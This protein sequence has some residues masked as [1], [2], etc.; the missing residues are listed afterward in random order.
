MGRCGGIKATPDQAGGGLD[1]D[2]PM[3]IYGNYH[4]HDGYLI[5]WPGPVG[6]LPYGPWDDGVILLNSGLRSFVYSPARENDCCASC[7]LLLAL[8]GPCAGC[9]RYGTM[10][11]DG[12]L[13][14]VIRRGSLR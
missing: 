1:E 7:P 9:C 3:Q 4:L 8:A 5:V 2:A 6:G 10:A 13:G 12:M 11:S 14:F